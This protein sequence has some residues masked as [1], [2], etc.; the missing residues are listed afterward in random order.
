LG[1]ILKAAAFEE[2]AIASQIFGSSNAKA[3]KRDRP[4]IAANSQQQAVHLSVY[5][6]R[7]KKE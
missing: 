3:A 5:D 4:S 6:S 7:Y 1:G 2:R